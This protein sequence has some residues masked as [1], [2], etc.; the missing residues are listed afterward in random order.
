MGS[1]HPSLQRKERATIEETKIA[2]L[3]LLRLAS[4]LFESWSK[5]LGEK[6]KISLTTKKRR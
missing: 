6:G 5:K 4:S 1:D 3:I 2:L